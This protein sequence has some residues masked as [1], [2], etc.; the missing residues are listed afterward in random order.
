MARSIEPKDNAEILL[1]IR[2]NTFAPLSGKAYLSAVQTQF[3]FD[4]D[5]AARS[6]KQ[7]SISIP[8][9][10]LS[11]FSPGDNKA[12]LALP[13][14][15]ALDLVLPASKLI[16]ENPIVNPVRGV[17]IKPIN[18]KK[19]VQTRMSPIK[20]PED[21]L[22]PEGNWDVIQH[23]YG[24]YH[25]IKI[26]EAFQEG[27]AQLEIPEL[28]GV[29]F[30]IDNRRSVPD[31]RKNRAFKLYPRSRFAKVQETLS[32]RGCVFSII[33]TSSRRSGESLCGWMKISKAK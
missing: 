31:R 14:N 19:S 9:E 6:E 3:P 2:N 30:R 4:A 17:S 25:P 28:P 33:T 16:S 20:I 27:E 23:R 21:A 1:K 5:V 18:L 11:M 10:R 15:V 26:F 32:P 8:V 7:F 24:L 29:S 12:E 22:K 13:G